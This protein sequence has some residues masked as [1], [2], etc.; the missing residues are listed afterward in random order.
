MRLF[1]HPSRRPHPVN[2]FRSTLAAVWRIATPY[3][4]SE[5]KWAGRGLL[6]AVIVIE[7]SLVGIDVLVNQWQNRFFNALQER[8]WDSFVREVGIFTI[9]AFCGI[10]LA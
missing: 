5:D 2:N 9:L 8:N 4:R 7:L 6:A 1:G 10:G 3:F